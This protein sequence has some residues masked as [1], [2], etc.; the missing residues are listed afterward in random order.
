MDQRLPSTWPGSTDSA[1]TLTATGTAWTAANRIQGSERVNLTFKCVDGN[2]RKFYPTSIVLNSCGAVH[3][4]K[5]FPSMDACAD[6]KSC[7]LHSTTATFTECQDK[8]ADTPGCVIFDH[9]A[10][11]KH[12][13]LQRGA[14]WKPSENP[15]VTS[16][17]L[18][19]QV[20]ACGK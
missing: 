14:A 13:W 17:C 15:R 11:S 3:G 19:A 12:C 9:N 5:V 8:C 18:V 16:G 10:E 6:S 20:P 4:S 2:N 1:V 7:T